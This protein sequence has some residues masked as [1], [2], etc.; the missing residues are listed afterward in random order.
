[1]HTISPSLKTCSKINPNTKF[2]LLWTRVKGFIEF[3]FTL[4]PG[5]RPP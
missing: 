4:S 2:S 1:M 3:P 5:L